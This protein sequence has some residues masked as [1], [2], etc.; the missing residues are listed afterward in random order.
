[1]QVRPHPEYN[2]EERH[3]ETTTKCSYY[4][5]CHNNVVKGVSCPAKHN[6]TSKGQPGWAQ[7]RQHSRQLVPPLAASSISQP[8]VSCRSQ[9]GRG[10]GTAEKLQELLI[11]SDDPPT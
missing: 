3:Q 5:H 2:G 6:R 9:P 1:M 8:V 4:P 10:H 11:T 7:H